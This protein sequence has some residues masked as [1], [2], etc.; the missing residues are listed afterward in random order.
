LN[1][2]PFVQKFQPEFV[3]DTFGQMGEMEIR[4]EKG[5]SGIRLLETSRRQLVPFFATISILNIS[6]KMLTTN[7]G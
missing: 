3:V 5:M 4:S 6:T 7:P 2:S 1:E